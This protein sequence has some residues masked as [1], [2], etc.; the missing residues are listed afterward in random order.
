MRWP[1]QI[2]S[3][4]ALLMAIIALP[5]S[6]GI[7]PS[8]NDGA[9]VQGSA[10][11]GNPCAL[12]M[13]SC[14]SPTRAFSVLTCNNADS[15]TLGVAPRDRKFGPSSRMASSLGQ[16]FWEVPLSR[17]SVKEVGQKSSHG[18]PLKVFF[19]NFRI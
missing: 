19:C 10:A 8:G 14:C 3:I 7:C 18:S 17:Y 13:M 4:V 12:R 6:A 11:A 2:A 15:S 5:Y 1:G 16:F 9:V